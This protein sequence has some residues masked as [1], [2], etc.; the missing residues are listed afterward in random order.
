MLSRYSPGDEVTDSKDH[1]DLCAL[2]SRYD[3]ILDRDRPSKIGCGI[4]Y[5]TKEHNTDFSWSSTGFWVHR[6]DGSSCDFSLKK[7]LGPLPEK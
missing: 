2:L 5:F 3:S 4:K 6:N 1:E 7:A